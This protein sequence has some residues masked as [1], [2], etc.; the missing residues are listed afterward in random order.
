MLEIERLAKQVVDQWETGQLAEAVR[1]LAAKLHAL[2]LRRNEGA[3]HV[4][5]LK[6][7][8]R[9]ASN[10]VEV[11]EEPLIDRTEDGY[12]ISVWHKVED[13][14]AQEFGHD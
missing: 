2:R 13:T 8:Y 5:H 12:W 14:S 4:A 7:Y 1:A 10:D 11:D 9:G 6:S 3:R